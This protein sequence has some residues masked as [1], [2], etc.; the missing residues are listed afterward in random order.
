MVEN[1]PLI[2]VF[3]YIELE[4]SLMIRGEILFP[5]T[6]LDELHISESEKEMVR[7]IQK[8][9]YWYS[10]ENISNF[11]FTVLSGA[12]QVKRI[13]EFKGHLEEIRKLI[14]YLYCIPDDRPQYFI[15]NGSY[16]QADYYLFTRTNTL[17]RGFINCISFDTSLTKEPNN[18][19]NTSTQERYIK[20]YTYSINQSGQREVTDGCRIYPITY[21]IRRAFKLDELMKRIRPERYNVSIL[22]L[23]YTEHLTDQQEDHILN[24]LEWYNRSYKAEITT[25]ISL[26]F[27]ATAFEVLLSKQSKNGEKEERSSRVKTIYDAIRTLIGDIPRLR[28]WF[29][30][31]YNAR[32]RILHEGE[33]SQMRFALEGS[34]K[35]SAKI[36][37]YGYLTH[38]GLLIFRVCLNTKLSGLIRSADID[39]KS[40]FFNNQERLRQIEATLSSTDDPY[41]A[42]DNIVNDMQVLYRDPVTDLHQIQLETIWNVGKHLAI[43]LLQLELN[44]TLEQQAALHK[45]VAGVEPSTIDAGP[46]VIQHIIFVFQNDNELPEKKVREYAIQQLSS[47]SPPSLIQIQSEI[48]KIL[49]DNRNKNISKKLRHDLE[50]ILQITEFYLYLPKFNLIAD[51]R[52]NYGG[53]IISK[54]FPYSNME[55]YAYFVAKFATDFERHIR[56]YIAEYNFRNNPNA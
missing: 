13:H 24:A 33:W 55:G 31:F 21:E 1:H 35:S 27:L 3:P 12:A 52:P 34:G 29:E 56:M 37:E 51:L 17:W 46:D 32:S 9:F 20:G 2:C 30:Q 7:E 22:R 36:N 47:E 14:G 44:I 39:L 16:E 54:R 18:S 4:E 25:D 40:K 43:R 42:I 6:S 8:Y 10:N 15:L 38:Y 50:Q 23:F 45:V 26:V 48:A 41:D 19:A 49:Q 53:D 28:E 5:Y 11:T